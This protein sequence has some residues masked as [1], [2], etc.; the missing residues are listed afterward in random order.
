LKDVLFVFTQNL[1]G[2]WVIE[3]GAMIEHLMSSSLPG[4]HQGCAAGFIRLHVGSLRSDQQVIALELIA[5]VVV[6]AA[7]AVL[8]NL[9]QE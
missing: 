3:D 9:C 2:E 5:R 8:E 6:C 7:G 4:D 1:H